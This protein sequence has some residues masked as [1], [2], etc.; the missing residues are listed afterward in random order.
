M[1]NPII[2]KLIEDL[3][4]RIVFHR[5]NAE[6]HRSHAIESLDE[7]ENIQQQLEELKRI[8]Q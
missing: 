8:V 6:Y 3:E 5:E 7:L 1:K 4:G 2:E